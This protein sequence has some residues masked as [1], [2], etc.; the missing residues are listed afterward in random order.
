MSTVSEWIEGHYEVEQ[1]S[2][3]QAYVWRPEQIV[4]ECECG[5]RPVL[6][7]SETICSCGVDH[8]DLVREEL[9]SWKVSDRAP[10]LW[11]AEYQE[12]RWGS[13]WEGWSV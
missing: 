7:A 6:N 11:E 3:G 4:V 9:A 12:W 10:H 5:E 1:T 2:Y 13:S 8:A